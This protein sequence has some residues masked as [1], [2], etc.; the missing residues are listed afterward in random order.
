MQ[1]RIPF[2]SQHPF[3]PVHL[4]VAGFGRWSVESALCF[5]WRCLL[6]RLGPYS[7]LLSRP[8]ACWLRRSPRLRTSATTTKPTSSCK[9]MARSRYRDRVVVLD[10]PPAFLFLLFFSSAVR[11]CATHPGSLQEVRLGEALSGSVGSSP[12]TPQR[13]EGDMWAHVCT[14]SWNCPASACPD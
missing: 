1:G 13:G 8:R 11:V 3:R 5:G 2:A 7:C 9:G 4:T 12:I 10:R 6:W 14:R